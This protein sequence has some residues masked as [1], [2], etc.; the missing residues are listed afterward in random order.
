VS[1]HFPQVPPP[2]PAKRVF[3]ATCFGREQT[4]VVAKFDVR[5][6]SLGLGAEGAK[7]E[8]SSVD[9]EEG[10]RPAQQSID[11]SSHNATHRSKEETA[12]VIGVLGYYLV[13]FFETSFVDNCL[14][15]AATPHH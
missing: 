8:G 3:R 1:P 11:T 13:F 2:R 14:I 7:G 15:G 9:V 6:E 4:T 10:G 12:G 5:G